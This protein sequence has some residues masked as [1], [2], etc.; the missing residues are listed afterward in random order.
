[1]LLWS[2]KR[3]LLSLGAAYLDFYLAEGNGGLCDLIDDSTGGIYR[4]E[5]ILELWPAFD[6][7]DL[8][9]KY[10]VSSLDLFNAFYF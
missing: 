2:M 5:L 10:E 1:M 8:Y 6:Y 3:K 7:L 9:D 4:D